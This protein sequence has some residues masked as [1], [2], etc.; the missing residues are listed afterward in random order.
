MAI[1]D[2]ERTRKER[3]AEA[4]AQREALEREQAAA[5]ARKR[6]L[7]WIGGGL[8]IVAVAVVI[9][10]AGASG[11]GSKSPSSSAGSGVTAGLQATA[12]PWAPEYNQLPTRLNAMNL[13][14]QS[15]VIFHI[16]AMLRVYVNGKQVPVPSQ[17][18]IDPQGQFLAPLHTHDASGVMH[19]EANQVY[20]FTLGQFF[21]VW[22]VKF[23]DTQIGSYVSNG[24]STLSAYANGKRIAD[25]VNYRMRAHDLIVVG[26]G[27]PG[28]FPTS[29]QAT[30]PAGE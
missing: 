13:P 7:T 11:G 18:G 8:A 22:G 30:F 3:R 4:R 14:V 10:V 24:T 5:A 20:P 9:A 12:A 1:K 16:H 2:D 28:S 26:Y 25:P 19:L 6:R 15:D 21:T 17:I 29:Y 27:T 23:T